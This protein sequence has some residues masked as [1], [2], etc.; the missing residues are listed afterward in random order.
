MAICVA[1]GGAFASAPAAAHSFSEQGS[2]TLTLYAV[3]GTPYDSDA[4]F[5]RIASGTLRCGPDGG[6]HRAPRAACDDLR[7]ANGFIDLVPEASGPCSSENAPV[8]AVAEGRWKGEPRLFGKVFSNRC[9]AV[10]STGGA[11]FRI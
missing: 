1:L 6:S 3:K 7:A 9:I 5:H 4:P 11:V 10:R 2:Y 8:Y